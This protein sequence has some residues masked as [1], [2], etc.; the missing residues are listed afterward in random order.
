MSIAKKIKKILPS[1][2]ELAYLE[3][4]KNPIVEKT[5]LFECSHGREI[6]GHIYALINEIQTSY[7]EYEFYVAVKKGVVVSEKFENNIVQH[8]SMSYL[9][10]LATSQILINDTSFWSFFDSG[11]GIEDI[12]RDLNGTY[13]WRKV[14]KVIE[15]KGSKLTFWFRW[16][17]RR[18]LSLRF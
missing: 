1:H 18:F 15:V 12:F 13:D 17:F 9:K 8:G 16:L 10:K 7:P 5:I 6:S 2:K 4:R 11:K 3:F 14:E